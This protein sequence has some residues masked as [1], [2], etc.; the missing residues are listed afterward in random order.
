MK[1]TAVTLACALLTPLAFAQPLIRPDGA[2]ATS[3]FNSNYLIINAINGSGLPANFTVSS[4]HADYAV[5]NHWTTR[6]G[7][8]IGQSATFTF[9]QPQTL[10]A[11]HMWAHRSNVIASNPHYAVT[12][13]DLV[14]RDGSGNIISS[15]SNLTGQ[16]NIAIAQTTTFDVI[17]GVRSV[18]FIV[19]ATANNNS[20]PY[21]GLA[22]VAFGPC[23]PPSADLGD[24]AL[25]CPGGDVNLTVQFGG[26]GART[27]AWEALDP[28]NNVIPLV[29]GPIPGF[30]AVLS[31][32]ASQTLVVSGIDA[33]TAANLRFRCVISNPC[34]TVASTPASITLC[35]LDFNCDNFV[36]FFDFDD[37]VSAFENGD[38]RADINGDLFLDFFDYDDFVFG[39]E[40]GC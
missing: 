11:F 10:G 15:L 13:F 24:S 21:T 25:T 4:P 8:T 37:F 14:F 22:E 1:Y 9:T 17:S 28:D 34:G 6:A 18:Q 39:F 36:D 16:P 3:E 38:M 33:N 30:S 23:I 26:S 35:N 19:R 29:D 2:T 40:A 20:S 27:F 32:T 7:E 31:G 5:R 12:L